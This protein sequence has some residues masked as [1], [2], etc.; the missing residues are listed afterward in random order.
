[1]R[2]VIRFFLFGPGAI[3]VVI[4]IIIGVA[5]II[6]EGQEKQRLEV[7]KHQVQ[8]PLGQ[9]KPSD[10]VDKSTAPKEVVLSDRRLNPPAKPEQPTQTQ[11]VS[12]P[13]RQLAQPLP[14]L[15]SFYA[16]VCIAAPS[17]TPAPAESKD[18]RAWLPPSIFI[19]CA[20]VNTVESSHIN[21]PVVGEVLHDVYQNGHLIVPAGAIASSFAQSGAVRDRIE[22]AGVWIIVHPDG[23]HLRVRG[24]A[25]DRE[26]DPANQQFGIEDGSAGLQGE[27]IESDHWANA[28]A[29]IALLMTA[30]MQTGTAVAT[31]TLQAAHTTG[32]TSLP[33]T[34]PI[35]A[36]YLDQLLNGETGDGRFVRVRAS[37][38][39]YLFVS[40]TIVPSRRTI[41]EEKA[42]EEDLS[43]VSPSQ[44]DKLLGEAVKMERTIQNAAQ[45]ER[46]DDKPPNFSY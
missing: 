7:E 28:K 14:S 41:E 35:L 30:T 22:V 13:P 19:P 26:A 15:V 43:K 23:R 16:Q 4:G 31:S 21:T 5:G 36:K 39:F 33:D 34:T 45:P 32:V 27:L 44:D 37:K 29:F 12:L 9:V 2:R 3:L 8:R 42:A 17:A 1:V 20:L 38:E 46:I 10:A 11:T 40:E 25:C 18:P 6:H 24:V